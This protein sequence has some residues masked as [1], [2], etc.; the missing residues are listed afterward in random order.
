MFHGISDCLS[1]VLNDLVLLGIGP[2]EDGLEI[3]EEAVVLHVVVVKVCLFLQVDPAEMVGLYYF[4]QL[5][6]DSLPLTTSILAVY[7]EILP[8][9]EGYRFDR[10]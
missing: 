10:N 5:V 8:H 9:E 7:S 4:L 2:G 6:Q 1:P 3:V